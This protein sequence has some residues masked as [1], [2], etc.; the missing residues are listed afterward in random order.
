MR[1]SRTIQCQGGARHNV[2]SASSYL[3]GENLLR[4]RHELMDL[5]IHLLLNLDNKRLHLRQVPLDTANTPA[6]LAH[7]FS[8]PH[9]HLVLV[10]LFLKRAYNTPHKRKVL[11]NVAQGLRRLIDVIGRNGIIKEPTANKV[12]EIR[13]TTAALNKKRA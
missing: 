11:S 3:H 2:H 7:P 6:P 8:P 9:T 13:R 5:G 1:C 10:V 4:L 12:S